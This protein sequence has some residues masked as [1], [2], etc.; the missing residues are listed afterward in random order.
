MRILV[1]GAAG[2]IGLHAIQKLKQAGHDVAG[3]DSFNDHYKVTLKEARAYYLIRKNIDV[4]F[5]DLKDFTKL[6][7]FFYNHQPEVVVHLA[8]RAGV[9]HSITNSVDYLNDNVIATHN[10]MRL[11]VKHDAKLI[12]AS[13]SSVYGG[14]SMP[15]DGFRE[16]LRTDEP[17]SYYA[18][19]KKTNEVDAAYFSYMFGLKAIGL[20]FFTVYGPWGRPDM[21]M[22]LWTEA[23]LKRKK[24]KLFNYGDMYRDFTYVDDITDGILSCIEYDPPNGSAIFNLGNNKSVKITQVVDRLI[25][26]LDIEYPIVEELPMQPGDVKRTFANIDKAQAC[27]GY[28][29][30]TSVEEGI[31]NFTQ[32]YREFYSG[33][34]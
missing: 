3:L 11:C 21:A 16:D 34:F 1:T 32:W 6:Q 14:G 4:I 30:K 17:I 8:A 27:L 10:I 7:T 31:K 20:R 15:K 33:M 29:P 19:T 18:A 28:E 5:L 9:R 12:Y 24:V 25:D 26:M 13:S 23:L 2:F 22:W